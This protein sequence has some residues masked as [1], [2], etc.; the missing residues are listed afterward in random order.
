MTEQYGIL[1]YPAKHSLSPAIHNAAFEYLGADARFG[2]LEVPDNELPAFMETVLTE[3]INGLAVSLPYK[4]VV[5]S[6]MDEID[7]DARKIGAVNTIVN[8]GGVLY[9]YN[10]DYIGFTKALEEV[11]GDIAGKSAVV[12]GAGGASR[13]VVYALLKAGA[14]VS[15]FNRTKEKANEL[16]DYFA[17]L[18]GVDIGSGSLEEITDSGDILI[19][20]TSAWLNDEESKIEDLMPEDLVAGYE[21]VMDIVYKPLIT[22]LIAAAQK[23]GAKAI[24]GEKMFLYQAAEQCKL[25]TGKDAPVEVMETVLNKFL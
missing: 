15:I 14:Q 3:P 2:F 25:W 5:M 12:I 7:E 20:T 13:G 17:N 4:E 23:A 6:Y 19:N 9:G 18:F 21:F 22:P 8:K 11:A 24:T 16:A 10:T 1:A